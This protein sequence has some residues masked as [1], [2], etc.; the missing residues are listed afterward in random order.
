MLLGEGRGRWFSFSFQSTL[1]W[2]PHI[3]KLFRTGSGINDS[4]EHEALSH[5]LS[6]KVQRID[7]TVHAVLFGI[8]A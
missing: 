7:H 2:L 4:R 5:L 8:K 3:V 6:E 1:S